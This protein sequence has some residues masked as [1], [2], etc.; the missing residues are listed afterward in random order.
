MTSGID[1]TA[2][3]IDKWEHTC[4]TVRP[5]TLT[6]V[7]LHQFT[8]TVDHQG[9]DIKLL[10][11]VMAAQITHCNKMNIFYSIIPTS[12]GCYIHKHC[13]VIQ[14]SPALHY[15]NSDLVTCSLDCPCLASA[16]QCEVHVDSFHWK[17]ENAWQLCEIILLEA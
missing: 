6:E 12:E 5:A 14:D 17:Q 4:Y 7:T 2:V 9:S 10:A 13:R 15:A 3:I 16:N 1:G 11:V 8:L